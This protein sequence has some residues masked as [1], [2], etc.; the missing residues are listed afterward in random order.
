MIRFYKTVFFFTFMMWTVLTSLAQTFDDLTFGTNDAL[1]IVTWNIEWF[2]KNGTTTVN[3]V[4][5][6]IEAIDVD[7]LAIQEI[8]DTTV[9]KGMINELENFDYVLMDGWFGGLV[10]VYN[11]DRIEIE[12]AFEIYTSSQYWN[13]L[14]RSPLVLKFKHLGETIYAINNHYKCC[15]D[16][17]IDLS[18]NGDEEV[19]R[20]TA[21]TLIENYISEFLPNERV[22]V[23]G[24]LNDLISEPALNNVFTPFLNKPNEYM[25]ADMGIATGPSSGWSYPSWPSHIDHILITDEL[26][27]DFWDINSTIVSLDIASHM[28][29]GWSSYDYN[30]S[31]HRPVGLRITP[32][33]LSINELSG[34]T[35]TTI[36]SDRKVLSITDVLGRQCNYEPGKILFFLYDDGSVDKIL[37]SFESQIE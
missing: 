30:I 17:Y 29:G 6:I 7:V 32:S 16:G 5:D 9:F 31:D 36:N 25:F 1:E 8:D 15:G 24:D 21:S 2:P 4:R 3:Y 13:P 20:L 22:I 35:L 12:D 14:P 23:L 19:R 34:N 28:S 18:D 37:S 27:S 10:Y 26:V 11:T 33:P